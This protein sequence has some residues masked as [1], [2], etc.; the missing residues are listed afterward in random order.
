MVGDTLED[1]PELVTSAVELADVGAAQEEPGAAHTEHQPIVEEGI[2]G[3]CVVGGAHSEAG[4]GRL[5]R[6]TVLEDG[7]G[8]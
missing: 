5:W 3:K 2:V 8:R 1:R 7:C 4:Q 6:V